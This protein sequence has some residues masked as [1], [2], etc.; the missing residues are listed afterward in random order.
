MED[1]EGAHTEGRRWGWQNMRVKWIKECGLGCGSNWSVS[2]SAWAGRTSGKAKR[3]W[4]EKL[5]DM[6][7][8]DPRVSFLLLAD[9]S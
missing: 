5:Q 2:W 4:S 8:I 1:D 3:P 9:P 6:I 7:F